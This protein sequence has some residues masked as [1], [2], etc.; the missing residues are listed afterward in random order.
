MIY[1][2]ITKEEAEKVITDIYKYMPV[3]IIQGGQTVRVVAQ[4]NGIAFYTTEDID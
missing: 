2:Q 4:K 1:Q 3:Y